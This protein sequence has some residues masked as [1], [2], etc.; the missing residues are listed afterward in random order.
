MAFFRIIIR[1]YTNEDDA[2]YRRYYEYGI[3]DDLLDQ[4]IYEPLVERIEIRTETAKRTSI[5]QAQKRLSHLASISLRRFSSCSIDDAFSEGSDGGKF[6]GWATA[7]ASASSHVD[8]QCCEKNTM[9]ATDSSPGSYLREATNTLFCAVRFR[10]AP[11]WNN[12]FFKTRIMTQTTDAREAAIQCIMNLVK[13]IAFG[14]DLAENDSLAY[15][16]GGLAPWPE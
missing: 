14:F 10:C 11:E 15:L 12:Y 6:Y 2:D 13:C 3:E 9:E 16:I 1:L 7:A 4:I 5:P 8:S